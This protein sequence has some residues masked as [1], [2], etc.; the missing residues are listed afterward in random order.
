M[1]N[2]YAALLKP[3][4]L[5]NKAFLKTV[6]ISELWFTIMIKTPHLTADPLT[7]CKGIQH[8]FFGR[9]GGVSQG[10]FES[11][12]AGLQKGDAAQNVTENRH[13]MAHA[14][15]M[16]DA[17]IVF[18]CQKHT[19]TVLVIDQPFEG[20]IPVADALITSTEN[21]IIG[22][23]TADCVPVLLADPEAKI[24][25]AIH[26]GWRGLATGIVQNT[27]LEMINIGATRHRII[28]A[29]G[30]CIWADS[31]EVGEDV[32][33]AFKSFDDVFKPWDRQSNNTCAE[34]T[35]TFAFDLP[36]AAYLILE[37]EGIVPITPSPIDTY[38]HESAYFSFRRSTH[39]GDERFG[40]QS[41][42][43]GLKE[44]QFGNPN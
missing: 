28:A 43:I 27:I 40:T 41:S 13:R 8:G 24:V 11:L 15:N 18:A 30:P 21:L 17:P 10:E 38:A 3:C 34:Q 32:H 22:V 36:R 35:V 33:A 20:E 26:G 16:N 44:M 9:R 39:K 25:A 37:H 7:Q 4:C 6:V 23:Q 1:Y 19:N 12:N 14:L 5:A 31:Y 2:V 42:L 29:I